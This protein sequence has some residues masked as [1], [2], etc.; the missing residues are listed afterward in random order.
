MVNRRTP[1]REAGYNL[2]FLVVLIALMGVATAA[3][4]PDLE[5]QI[6]REKEAELIFR[7]MQYAEGL[8]VFQQRFGR[9][10]NRLEE[11]VELEPRSMRQLWPDPM[12]EDGRWGVVLA[13]GQPG[14]PGEGE[15]EPEGEEAIDAQGRVVAGGSAPRS[16]FRSDRS[17][18][19]PTGGPIVGVVSREKGAAVRTFLG[20]D[21]YQQWRFTPSILPKPQVIPGTEIVVRASVENLG[22]PFPRGLQPAGFPGGD[23]AEDLARG[24]APGD[25]TEPGEPTSLA[26]PT[27]PRPGGDGS[28][29]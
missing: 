1:P 24:T 10:P 2:V 19:Q 23:P 8:R 12:V 3:M 14:V 6:Q 28:D 20:E 5:Q 17:R 4:L 27:I 29:G 25:P 22:K 15:A 13:G 21:S 9:Y 7:G 18:Q 26:D 11:L 16:S